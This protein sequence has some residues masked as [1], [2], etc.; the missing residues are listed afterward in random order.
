MRKRLIALLLA[1]V[2]CLGLLSACGS[3][4]SDSSDSTE[5]ETEEAAE[6]TEEAEAAEETEEAEEAE[7]TEEAEEAEEEETD[8]GLTLESVEL[9]IFEETVSLTFWTSL[10]FFM[11]GMVSDMDED[12]YLLTELQEM[13]NFDLEVTS[14]NG[15]A[16]SEQFALMIAAGDYC[17]IISGIANYT[18][19]YDAAISDEVIIDLYD[20]V[21]EYAPNY[22]Y[23]VNSSDDI[24]AAILTDDGA[25]P[26]I[27]TI[28]QETGSENRG[29]L[30]RSD[31]LEELGLDVPTTYDELHDFV[32]ACNVAYGSEGMAIGGGSGAGVSV[33]GT[34]TQLSYGLDFAIGSYNVIDGEVVYSYLNDA[35][36]DYFAL[37]AEWYADG[38]IAQDFYSFESDEGDQGIPNGQYVISISSAANITSIATY[39]DEG[40]VY[41]IAA[42]DAPTTG[43]G[44]QLHYRWTDDYSPLKRRD[45][46]AITVDCEHPEYVLQ[47]VNYLFSDEGVL[48]FNYGTEGYTFEYDENGDPQ[49]TDLITNN[50]DYA[51]SYATYIFVSNVATEYLPGIMDATV[52]YYYFSDAEWEVFNTFRD[53]DADGTY[54]LPTAVSLTE[55]E[56]T[57]YANYSTDVTTYISTEALKF[58]TVDGYLTEESFA[59]FQQT[60]IDMGGEEMEAIYQSAYERYLEK[61]E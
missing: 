15:M 7:E 13:C 61:L 48:F 50:P 23:Y 26:T 49:Y 34:V 10:P 9:P 54:N 40:A 18:T 24:R 21:Q 33:A 5:T 36:Y 2:L 47:I 42:M 17:D 45:S 3:S 14:V 20:L 39:A 30:Y 56:N 6:E 1:L 59:E 38:T 60:I 44:E 22:W 4:S 11:E 46:W 53:C 28:Y 43:D 29:I 35:C 27:A 16:E 8:N 52:G 19:G 12:L 51:E 55:E 25:L 57:E 32:Q 58:I 31:W 41:E 37:M